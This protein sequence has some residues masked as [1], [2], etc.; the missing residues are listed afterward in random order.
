MI[1]VNWNA[2][3]QLR[4]CLQSIVAA[5]MT[6]IVLP[7]VV[8]VDNDSTDGSLSGLEDIELPLEIIR[9]QE[10]RGFG[11]ACNQGAQGSRADYLLFLNPDVRLSTN[12]LSVP[13][14]FME[15]PENGRVGICGIQLIDDTGKVA[16]TCA[17]FPTP[18]RFIAKACGLSQLL[19]RVFPSHFMI[20]W[21][22]GETRVV[23]QV[24][25]AFFLVRRSLFEKLG[26]FDERFFVYFEDLD[27]SLRAHDIGWE[28]VYLAS[29]RA[30]HRGC[31]TSDRIPATRLF[32]SLRSRI[33]Y[34][35]KHFSFG[36]TVLVTLAT[37]FI[38][39]VARIFLA[40]LYG[41]KQELHD[42]LRA[43]IL[44]WRW[45][46][47]SPVKPAEEEQRK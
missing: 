42:T 21:D 9:N 30:F 36:G 24:M 27:F 45:L 23:D 20:E 38:E 44:L 40:V 41:S 29:S 19:P 22:H 8:V 4:E 10:N 31:G 2:G 12:S 18:G 5:E 15:R 34:A 35:R 33:Q 43:F 11:A 47:G 16:R 28:S 3:E 26:G 17:R 39:P 7:R 46:A 37:L 6:G 1:I 25:G 14:E 13:L 32:Y